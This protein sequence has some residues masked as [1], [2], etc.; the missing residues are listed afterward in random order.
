MTAKIKK[1]RLLTSV[2]VVGILLQNQFAGAAI[3]NTV[4]ANATAPS[5]PLP[6]VTANESVD[7][8]NPIVNASIV[9]TWSFAPGGDVNNNG[10]VDA[11]DTVAYT[12]LVTNTGN[13]SLSNVDVTDIAD[14]A[15]GAPIA[16]TQPTL[17]TTDS[18]T[19]PPAQLAAAGQLNDS[20]NTAGGSWDVLGP[21][22]VITFTATYVVQAGDLT[23]PGAA[24]SDIDSTA[25]VTG[26]YVPA[27]GPSVAL[28]TGGTREDSE[29]VPLN[30]APVLFVD[31]VASD[32]TD[33]AAGDV[34]TY[35]YTVRND[36]NV[37]LTTV[38]LSDV[39]NGNNGVPGTLAPAFQNFTINTGSTNT[40][41]TINTL[42]PGDE[43]IFT[44]TYVV[45]QSDINNLQ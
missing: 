19:V 18:G 34:I 12:Y 39:H 23:S 5:G 41:N 31:K 6:P 17:V 37:P 27:T 3:T 24:D 29:A 40:G 7:V 32:T 43:A 42:Q 33:V 14:E 16:I 4:T 36:G 11:G 45:K 44:A 21:Q 20:S 26:T 15:V 13:V 30:I 25:R 9:K 22:D 38:T 2:A 35:T 1:T 10:L 8:A 28:A